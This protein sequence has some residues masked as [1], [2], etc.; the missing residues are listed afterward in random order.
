MPWILCQSRPFGW[1]LSFNT[2]QS[3]M[4]MS[5][6]ELGSSGN[7]DISG[8]FMKTIASRVEKALKVVGRFLVEQCKKQSLLIDWRWSHSSN[9]IASSLQNP[10]N[11]A[12][13]GTKSWN[14]KSLFSITELLILNSRQPC[15][16]S[17]TDST[18]RF[19]S[20][21]KQRVLIKGRDSK[22]Q[23]EKRLGLWKPPIF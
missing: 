15:Q 10:I 1:H 18:A 19:G 3:L 14:D 16:D 2:G 9:N 5:S 7:S 22:P 17:R 11:N 12:R 20:I 21:P 4:L 6:T 13:G 23:M 8:H